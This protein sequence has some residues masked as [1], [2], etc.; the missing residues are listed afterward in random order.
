VADPA[1]DGTVVAVMK[2]G[3]AIGDEILRPAAVVVGTHE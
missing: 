3:Y 1:Q 2:E